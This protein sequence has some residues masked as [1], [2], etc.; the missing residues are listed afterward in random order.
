MGF[1]DVQCHIFPRSFVNELSSPQSELKISPPDSNGRRVITDSKSGDETTYFIENSP[2]V[3][4]E[5]HIE[6]MDFFNIDV[7]LLSLPAPSVDKMTNAKEALRV[8][9]LI[10]DDLA[11]IIAV[12]PE[13]FQ[14]LATIS[15]NDPELAV[16]EIKRAFDKL[17]FKG[18]TISSNTNGV[19]YDSPKYEKVFQTM[20]DYDAPV[21]IHPTEPVTSRVIGQD[22]K[23]VL[24]FGWPFDTT[25]S[26]SRLVFSG[27]LRKFPRLKIIAAHGGGM[28]PFF[29]GRMDI[30]AKIAA[31]GAQKIVEDKPSEA[32]KRLYYDA[33]LFDS[34]SLELL[35]KFAGADHVLFAS[36]YP[37]G[38][39]LG[40]SCY[41]ESI[42]MM[43]KL[44]V[45][46]REKEL[47]AQGNA[48]KIFR[49]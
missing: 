26:I 14:G 32:C 30:L 40:K 2:Y 47:I 13:R 42:K 22:Y 4:Y 15:M 34:D 36:D 48:K 45:S 9:S 12:A 49:I 6:D 41:E 38:R 8:S 29:R 16:R 23:L 37:F 18:I 3:D 27:M 46:E 10:N 39:N 28:I 19:F 24:I 35:I 20:E 43:E 33:A 7:Q 1:V 11:K 31:G 5:K 25:L 17:G 21:F 44:N